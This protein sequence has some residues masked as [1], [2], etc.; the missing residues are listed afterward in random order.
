MQ[1]SRMFGQQQGTRLCLSLCLSLCLLVL[2]T[3]AIPFQSDASPSL[4]SSSSSLIKRGLPDLIR[5]RED[6]VKI[7]ESYVMGAASTNSTPPT[8]TNATNGDGDDATQSKP[9]TPSPT[10]ISVATMTRIA[11]EAASELAQAIPQL[12]NSSSSSNITATSPSELIP[13][14]DG[15]TGGKCAL[16]NVLGLSTL[17]TVVVEAELQQGLDRG[18]C[19][20]R[21]YN[22]LIGDNAAE[23]GCMMTFPGGCNFSDDDST[24]SYALTFT[25]PMRSTYP[26]AWFM[27]AET[28]AQRCLRNVL[29]KAEG[30]DV[31]CQLMSVSRYLKAMATGEW[32]W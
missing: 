6:Q 23:N 28:R 3:G 14:N 5:R 9:D 27:G 15:A 11:A 29:K 24:A 12:G 1:P 13:I 31:N 8:N 30:L 20:L 19:G 32:D 10:Q 4:L 18:V 21:V 22:E 25:F 2:Q 26:F 17:V 7:N 16:W